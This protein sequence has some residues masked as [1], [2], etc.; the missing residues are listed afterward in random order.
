MPH[1]AEELAKNNPRLARRVKVPIIARIAP[2]R[3]N[4]RKIKTIP[5]MPRRKI[6][7]IK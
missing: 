7:A 6:M 4:S 2:G 3:K 1:K 5:A